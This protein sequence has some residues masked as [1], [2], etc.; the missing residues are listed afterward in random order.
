MTDSI[1]KIFIGGYPLKFDEME[2]VQL[3]SPYGQVSSIKIVRDKVSLKPKGYAFLEMVSRQAAE[4]TVIGLDGAELQGKAL[5]VSLVEDQP[6]M[7]Y[8]KVE[9]PNGPVKKKRP[10][11]PK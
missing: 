4:D 1:T 11:L 10:R 2:L 9:R 5:S 6:A 7:A 8:K 3:V